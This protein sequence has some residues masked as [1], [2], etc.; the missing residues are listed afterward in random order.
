MV[1]NTIG[2]TFT[3]YETNPNKAAISSDLI[4]DLAIYTCLLATWPVEPLS[5]LFSHLTGCFYNTDPVALLSF[6]YY[7]KYPHD[8]QWPTEITFEINCDWLWENPPVAHKNY[9]ERYNWII[10]SVISPESLKLQA[11]NLP[12]SYSYSGSIRLSSLQCIAGW[13]F[14]HFRLFL[15]TYIG[16]EGWG[17]VGSHK[18]ASYRW[19]LH[20]SRWN[21]TQ[22][23]PIA[24][25]LSQNIAKSMAYIINQSC[26]D[27]QQGGCLYKPTSGIQ[28]TPKH[29]CTSDRPQKQASAKAD[30]SAFD[31]GVLVISLLMELSVDS[32]NCSLT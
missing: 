1:T 20:F 25:K 8:T 17:V 32:E 4:R 21:G 30:L 12:H 10:R 19:A 22:G 28:W 6:T 23:D 14:H 9:L 15:S 18:V 3:F 11:C 16:V 27:F 26:G 13:I 31:S 2:L 7:S 29:L 5:D 24:L